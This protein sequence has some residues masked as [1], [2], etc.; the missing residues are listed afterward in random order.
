MNLFKNGNARV[1]R[2][3]IFE[4]AF[5]V[6]IMVIGQVLG[7]L[8]SQDWLSPHTIK[9]VCFVLGTAQVTFKG[10][11]MFF[12]KTAALFTN[13]PTETETPATPAKTE[14]NKQ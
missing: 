14:T 11:E 2:L 7:T 13:H 6:A 1:T 12:S 10:V 9:I 5:G 8:P 3:V 4:M